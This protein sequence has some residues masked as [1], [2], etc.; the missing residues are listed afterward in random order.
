M[1][2][3]P[4][5]ILM[6]GHDRSLLETRQWVLQ[7]RGYRVIISSSV[8]ALRAPNAKQVSLLLLCHSLTSAER[9][10]AIAL[11]RSRWP[12]IRHL[13]IDADDT[14]APNGIL[15]SLLHTMNGPSKLIS[16]VNEIMR[17]DAAPPQARAS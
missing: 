4:V 7:S 13:S 12:E 10:T 5:V 2:N 14:R 1:K 11:A 15:G 3:N 9:D 17:A 16:M 6:L 8:S